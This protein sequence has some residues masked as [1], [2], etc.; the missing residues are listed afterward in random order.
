MS[1]IDTL[2]TDRTQADVQ[3]VAE[4]SAKS[5]GGMTAAELAEWMSGLK[6][7]YNATDLNRVGSALAYIAGRLNDNGFNITIQPKTDWM[8]D[9]IPSPQQLTDYKSLIQMIRAEIAY[10]AD[11]P[12]A[13][14][15]MQLTY[16]GANDIETILVTAEELITKMILAY[17]RCGNPV[18]GMGGLMT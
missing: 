1:V 14:D 8:M 7:S 3:R 15:V 11:T 5:Y 9:D 16:S 18:L 2:I 17:R 4:L 6:G 12:E 13:P 10:T